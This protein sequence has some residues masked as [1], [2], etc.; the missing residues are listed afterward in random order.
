M[1]VTTI[2]IS[3]IGLIFFSLF[4]FVLAFTKS[5]RKKASAIIKKQKENLVWNGIIVMTYINYIGMMIKARDMII[6]ENIEKQNKALGII[7]CLV[8]LSYPIYISYFLKSNQSELDSAGY[9]KK[10]EQFYKEVSVVNR[11]SE[12]M[13]YYPLFLTKRWLL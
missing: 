8:L 7:M 2:S 12:N 10:Y 5:G 4:I 13:L 1:L 9:R 3:V 6:S 11:D